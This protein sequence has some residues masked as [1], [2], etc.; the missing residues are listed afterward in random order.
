MLKINIPTWQ[1][2]VGVLVATKQNKIICLNGWLYKEGCTKILDLFLRAMSR[3]VEWKIFQL[4][5]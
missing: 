1:D 3:P 4:M 2:W 5:K